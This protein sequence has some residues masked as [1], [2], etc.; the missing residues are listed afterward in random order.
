MLVNLPPRVRSALYSVSVV[1]MP[2]IAYLTEQEVINTFWAGLA[3]VVNSAVLL[4]AR[5]N[6]SE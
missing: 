1:A 6:V 4:L 5:V 3:V 2:I